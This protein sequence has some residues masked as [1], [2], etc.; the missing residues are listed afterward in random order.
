ME[1][2]EATGYRSGQS[3]FTKILISL[4]PR[5]DQLAGPVLVELAGGL[6]QFC[7]ACID[8]A[9]LSPSSWSL[10]ASTS[11]SSHGAETWFSLPQTNLGT[12][13]WIGAG[14][15]QKNL[16]P[17]NSALR[18]HCFAK[19]VLKSSIPFRKAPGLNLRGRCVLFTC[20]FYMF[21]PFSKRL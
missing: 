11:P 9:S 7:F 10:V 14:R 12:L 6:I 16:M 15:I 20:A 17:T 5:V 13:R 1:R 21:F 3:I 18:S 19:E 2:I 4:V 8:H